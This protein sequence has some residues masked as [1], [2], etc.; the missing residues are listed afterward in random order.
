LGFVFNFEND[1]GIVV[2]GAIIG[3]FL[4]T[5]ERFDSDLRTG[6]SLKLVV[7]APWQRAHLGGLFLSLVQN[8]WCH[9]SPHT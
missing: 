6:K 2:A 1:P 3:V 9:D 8:L 4:F 7:W 5:L